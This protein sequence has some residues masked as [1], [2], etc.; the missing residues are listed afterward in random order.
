MPI[1]STLMERKPY[2]SWGCPK[3]FDLELGPAR[4]PCGSVA[5]RPTIGTL[6]SVPYKRADVSDRASHRFPESEATIALLLCHKEIQYA[7]M[8]HG[9]FFCTHRADLQL[10]LSP[11]V[12]IM[13]Y[14]Y[15]TRIIITLLFLPFSVLP[16]F[17]F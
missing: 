4:F 10:D 3:H 15:N 14:N 7:Q 1:S 9:L 6:D 13:Y 17:V 12:P 8:L 16:V 5:C 11:P 2:S